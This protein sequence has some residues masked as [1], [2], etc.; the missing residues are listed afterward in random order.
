MKL[1]HEHRVLLAALAAGAPAVLVAMLMLWLGNHSTKVQW[2]LTV[3]IVGFWLG[4]GFSVRERVASP[5]R[6]L[7][8]LL[9]AM[10]EGDYSIRARGTRGGDAMSEVMV[11]VNAM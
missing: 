4:F 6:T 2:T 5:L 1:A 7:A 8:N 10:R 3:V 11:Q 9:E